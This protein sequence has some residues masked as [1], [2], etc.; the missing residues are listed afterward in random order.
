MGVGQNL[1][2]SRHKHERVKKQQQEKQGM[3]HGLETYIN[4]EGGLR[5]ETMKHK[6]LNRQTDTE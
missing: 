1:V 2:K 6:G 4:M 3:N 5:T